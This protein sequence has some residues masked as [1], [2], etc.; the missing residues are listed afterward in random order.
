MFPENQDN[1]KRVPHSS[2]N[3]TEFAIVRWSES[4]YLVAMLP[5]DDP[6]IGLHFD[7][8][9]HEPIDAILPSGHLTFVINKC[10]HVVIVL[11]GRTFEG[12][13]LKGTKAEILNEADGILK[14]LQ[15][16]LTAEGGGAPVRQML[17]DIRT[18]VSEF[19]P[20]VGVLVIHLSMEPTVSC[21]TH[22]IPWA[23]ILRVSGTGAA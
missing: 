9:T 15:T 13:V 11:C 3:Q 22:M 10:V 12:S 14:R 18:Q 20:G 21:F 1:A 4:D 7:P 16:E 2:T 6:Q 5:P 8:D 23:D 19:D 17:D